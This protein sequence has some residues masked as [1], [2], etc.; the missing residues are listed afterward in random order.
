[1]KKL[2][3][4]VLTITHSNLNQKDS[5]TNQSHQNCSIDFMQLINAEH[6]SVSA[7]IM[8]TPVG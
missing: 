5:E 4:I 7:F 2:I 8:D 1:M 6:L 3:R